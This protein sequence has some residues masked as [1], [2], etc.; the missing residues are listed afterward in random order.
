MQR[1]RDHRKALAMNGYGNQATSS[2]GTGAEMRLSLS[3]GM[4]IGIHGLAHAGFCSTNRFGRLPQ[5][6]KLAFWTQEL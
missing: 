4:Y 2:T 6:P 1:V 3:M 5:Y